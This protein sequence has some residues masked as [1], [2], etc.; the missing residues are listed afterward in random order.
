MLQRRSSAR[1][2][3]K[4]QGRQTGGP[5][6]GNHFLFVRKSG[7]RLRHRAVYGRGESRRVLEEGGRGP[8]RG[9]GGDTPLL[10]WCMAILRLAW[11]KASRGCFSCDKLCR[12]FF[13]VMRKIQESPT[14][15]TRRRAD[16]IG[17]AIAT[18]AQWRW[19]S[20]FIQPQEIEGANRKCTETVNG[21]RARDL[22]GRTKHMQAKQLQ[23]PLLDF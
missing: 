20:W 16:S 13:Q 1:A 22:H 3:A 18:V 15:L 8:K 23:E 5:P 4:A 14:H 17:P 2:R 10:L 9:G 12:K 21:T 6:K 7:K 19:P 11:G